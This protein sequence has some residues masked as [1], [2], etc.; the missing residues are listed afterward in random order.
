MTQDP[1]GT[2]GDF[3]GRNLG[4]L[5]AKAIQSKPS[6]ESCSLHARRP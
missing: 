4:V 3:Q 2:K 6:A 1:Q 5:P